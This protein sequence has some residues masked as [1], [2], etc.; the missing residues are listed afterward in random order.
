MKDLKFK[1][2]KNKI[3]NNNYTIIND[4]PLNKNIVIE[5]MVDDSKHFKV[6][7]ELICI[8]KLSDMSGS[9][10]GLFINNNIKLIKNKKYKFQGRLISLKNKDTSDFDVLMSNVIKDNIICDE[11]FCI[12][13]IEDVKENS[14]I[15]LLKISLTHSNSDE[16][17]NLNIPVD[18]INNFEIFGIKND[19]FMSKNY[20]FVDSLRF[21]ECSIDL[22]IDKLNNET[23]KKLLNKN[24]I[25][26]IEVVLNNGE[27]EYYNVPYYSDDGLENQYQ[28]IKKINN[29]ISIII[30]KE[31]R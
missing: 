4:I 21:E 7:N 14:K 28:N 17:I 1:K 2:T 27:D 11:L 6:D 31:N 3:V 29:I 25:Y 18:A 16:L 12:A 13:A 8:I 20:E 10:N 15:K 23:V 19:R 24:I 22:N 9:I 26:T 30:D 5:A